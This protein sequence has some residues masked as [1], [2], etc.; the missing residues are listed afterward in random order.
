MFIDYKLSNKL[1]IAPSQI[2]QTHKHFQVPHRHNIITILKMWWQLFAEWPKKL[3][4]SEIPP[5][6][7]P[8]ARSRQK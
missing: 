6:F 2:P 8:S 3:L 5:S 1:N 4:R 7:T